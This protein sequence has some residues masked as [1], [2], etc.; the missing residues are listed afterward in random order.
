MD[1][2]EIGLSIMNKQKDRQSPMGQVKQVFAG[3]MDSGNIFT[4]AKKTY[5]KN[6][7]NYKL[8]TALRKTTGNIL[9]DIYD[10]G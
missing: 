4:N 8:G 10:K 2:G 5:N 7:K 1:L 9:G 6:N 3:E